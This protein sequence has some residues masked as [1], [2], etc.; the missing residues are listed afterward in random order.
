MSWRV[1][2]RPEVEGDIAEAADW[3]DSR[4]EGL[5]TEFREEVIQV[6][7]IDGS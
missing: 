2:A 4:Q 3:H 6:L 7:F 5:G 1:L